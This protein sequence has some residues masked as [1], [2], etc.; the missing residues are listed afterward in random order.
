M[1]HIG[2]GQELELTVHHMLDAVKDTET[3][4]AHRQSLAMQ[5]DAVYMA[6]NQTLGKIVSTCC[7]GH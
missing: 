6:T 2:A 5:A 1:G 7:L 3:W 4:L